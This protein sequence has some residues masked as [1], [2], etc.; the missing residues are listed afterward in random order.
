MIRDLVASKV[1]TDTVLIKDKQLSVANKKKDV[2]AIKT[3][4]ASACLKLTRQSVV[5]ADNDVNQTANKS[6]D[7]RAASDYI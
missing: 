5:T 1:N 2:S 3:F 4:S 6:K 7:G